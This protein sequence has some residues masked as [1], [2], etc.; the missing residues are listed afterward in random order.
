MFYIFI[1]SVLWMTWLERVLTFIFVFLF[2]FFLSRLWWV[3]IRN[4]RVIHKPQL[5]IHV[6]SQSDLRLVHR[7]TSQE[8]TCI[9]RVYCLQR[10]GCWG[11]LSA[12]LRR[13]IFWYYSYSHT[14]WTVLWNGEYSQQNSSVCVPISKDCEHYPWWDGESLMIGRLPLPVGVKIPH[15]PIKKDLRNLMWGI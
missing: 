14:D 7:G 10:G 11:C 13:S 12:G 2:F 9:V 6:S 15:L 4:I 5:S 3:F 8:A 1:C